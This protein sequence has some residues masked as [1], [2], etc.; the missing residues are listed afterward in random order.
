MLVAPLCTLRVALKQH[1]GASGQG[2][3]RG[4]LANPAGICYVN[5]KGR[6]VVRRFIAHS[7]CESR[8]PVTQERH[9]CPRPRRWITAD[10]NRRILCRLLLALLPA[11]T[12]CGGG[13]V[14]QISNGSAAV[15]TL[16][17]VMT[18]CHEDAENG[19]SI[20]QA[21]QIRRG[22]QPAITV[23]DIPSFGAL[24]PIPLCR[25]FADFHDGSNSVYAGVFQRLAVTPDGSGV[26]FEV[27]FDFSLLKKSLGV[28][29]PLRSDQEG[30]FFIRADGSGLR[31]LGP[32]SK[33]A[34][35][36]LVGLPSL[37]RGRLLLHGRVFSAPTG[38]VV[39][40][41]IEG[42]VPAAKT[43]LRS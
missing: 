2:S 17:Y 24:P 37:F 16:A 18:T 21:L 10:G 15:R 5:G 36:N 23:M 25:L 33:E 19:L 39:T 26:V 9:D 22:D 41:P 14:T 29:S 4:D 28:D 7:H 1:V 30:I 34:S 43:P 42:R 27:T 12:A 6:G 32:A 31:R 40:S 35:Q 38:R 13:D 3:D 20:G 8:K 11:L